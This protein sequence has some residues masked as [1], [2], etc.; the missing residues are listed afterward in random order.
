MQAL[1]SRISFTFYFHQGLLR[2]CLQHSAD[3]CHDIQ[4]GK[5]ADFH[6]HLIH[7][8]SGLD[9]ATKLNLFPSQ[10]YKPHRNNISCVYIYIYQKL[11]TTKENNI[12]QLPNLVPTITPLCPFSLMKQTTGLPVCKAPS[13]PPHFSKLDTNF[14]GLDSEPKSIKNASFVYDQT[15][16]IHVPW[17]RTFPLFLGVISP[18]YWRFKTFIF[19]WVV[20][21]QR[22]SIFTYMKTHK[23]E[24][25]V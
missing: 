2:W 4:S 9:N 7:N 13:W 24:P 6:Q 11:R 1:I 16:T 8:T 21:V 17:E 10:T 14:L 20:G 19:P 3:V 12:Y 18:I 23:N 5:I 25:N 22:Y 15:Q